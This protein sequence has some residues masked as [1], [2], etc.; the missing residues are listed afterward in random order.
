MSPSSNHIKS[1]KGTSVYTK[2]GL[3]SD[4]NWEETK[5]ISPLIAGIV[6]LLG[7]LIAAPILLMKGDK[8]EKGQANMWAGIGIFIFLF[9]VWILVMATSG[10]GANS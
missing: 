7:L 1:W 3:M 9:V 10:P 2:K 4:K 5:R 6:F 8:T